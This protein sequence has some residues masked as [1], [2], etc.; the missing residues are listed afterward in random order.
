MNDLVLAP[1]PLTTQGRVLIRGAQVY[2]RECLAEFLQRNGVDLERAQWAVCIGGAQVPSAMWRHTRPAPGQLIVCRRVPG[3]EAL[4]IVATIALVAFSF[5]TAAWAAPALLANVGI[6]G[7]AAY[8]LQAGIFMLGSLLINKVLPPARARLN[9]YDS[10][11]GSTY[12]LQ[13]GRNRARPYEPLGLVMGV[14]KV[15]PDFAAQPFAWFDGDDQYQAIRLHAGI[16]CGSVA[17]LKIGPT[18]LSA[19][20]DVVESRQGFPTGNT[21][22]ADWEDVDTQA[23]AALDA[24]SGPGAWV[25]RTSSLNTVMLAVDLVA[26]L[27]AMANDGT[28]QA[29]LLD[30]DLEYRALPAGSW[31]PLTGLGSATVRLESRATKPVRRT[32]RSP[33]LAP[34]QYEVRVRKVTAN[35]ATTSKSNAVEWTALKSYQELSGSAAHPQLALRIRAT[36]QLNGVLDEVSWIATQREIP[37][38]T[39]VAWVDQV[40]RNP[41]AH[42]LRLAR[43]IY[44]AGR[45]QAG[46][47]LPDDQIDIETLQAFMVHCD[48]QGYVFDH[49]FDAPMSCIDML[50][51]IAAAGLGSISWHPGKLSV[52]WLAAGQPIEDVVSMANIKAGSFAV[53]YTTL[54]AADELE[55]TWFDRDADWAARSLRLL[56]PGVVTPRETARYAPVGVTTEAGAVRAGRLTMAQNIYQRKSVSWEMDLEHMAFRRWSVIAL[57]HD[58]TQWG[59]SGRL[60]GAVDSLGTVTLTLDEAVPWNAGAPTRKLGLRIP[61]EVGYRLFDLAVFAGETRTLTLVGAWPV[62]VP[63]PGDSAANPVHDT[64]WIYDFAAT[65][66]QRLR[67]TSIEPAADLRGARI[68]AVPESDAF[69]TYMSSGSYEVSVAPAAPPAIVLSNLTVTQRRLDVNYAQ[70]TELSIAFDVSGPMHSAQ[71]WGAPLGDVLQLLGVTVVSRFGPWP[72]GN[73]GDYR[74]EVR[75]FDALG[76]PGTVLGHTH[77]V[78]LG[79]ALS[80]GLGRNLLDA[81]NWVIGTSDS[82]TGGGATDW[83]A[84]GTSPGGS[85]TIVLGDGP[86]EVQRALWRALSGTTGTPGAEG[87]IRWTSSLR[88]DASKPY[89]FAVWVR[90]D[91][92]GDGYVYLGCEPN[93][94]DEVPAGTIDPNPYFFTV[95]RSVL[96][97]NRWYLLTGHVLPEGYAGAQLHLSGVYDGS[98]GEKVLSGN[99]FRWHAGVTTSYFRAFQ[100]YTT[101]SGRELLLAMP[102]VDLLDGNEPSTAQLIAQTVYGSALASAQALADIADDDLLTPGEKPRVILDWSVISGEQAGIDA[103]ASARNFTTEQDA[104]DDAITALSTYLGTLTTPVAWNNLSGN[105]TI[106]GATFRAKFA[107]V[108]AARQTL[109]N[110]IAGRNVVY[111]Q[112]SA[113]SGVGELDGDLWFDTDDGNRVYMRSGGSWATVDLG[114]GALAA[115]AATTGAITDSS[116]TTG[117]TGS[118]GASTRNCT[119]Y[120]PYVTTDAGDELDI[121][122]SGV[123]EETFWSQALYGKVELKMTYAA[124]FG[125]SETEFATRRKFIVPIDVY[126][127]TTHIPIDMAVQ[128]VPGAGSR[129]LIVRASVTYIDSS[130]AAVTCAKDFVGNAQ[131][132]VTRRKR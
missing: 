130:G 111:R 28:M 2:P 96:T 127:T 6:T 48:A 14:V 33:M 78:V 132:R 100:F 86:D 11:T 120:G 15:V 68:T 62:G 22:A 131:W 108:Y 10:A 79:E 122:V 13:G 82:Q 21:T 92:G 23:G 25:T 17:T 85:N 88:V 43:G 53:E 37:V 83:N 75:P 114:T 109:L 124:T 115:H 76:R 24:P 34:G 95:N 90:V 99:D 73:D 125:G 12:S 67:V 105:T 57:S 49:W 113:P 103:Q 84:L 46:L 45:L 59:Y 117:S 9:N 3:K 38:W 7:L 112:A 102:R 8:G 16:D 81:S 18:P 56:A 51:A 89:R 32:V 50:E 87:G 52:V 101:G 70:G 30:V 47:G 5:G 63:F 54:A 66:G 91:G 64:I 27:Y 58:L 110:R 123:L 69:W 104:Y 61:G 74:I 40:S 80:A 39:G 4:R 97:P 42:I 55:V 36:G 31:A 41:G 116:E 93:T 1:H 26:Q 29:A 65:P 20:S 119:L 121:V 35:V 94:V 71:V 72:V 77:S 19:Y 126:T 118:P 106:V 128:F 107:D 44:F 98:S 129:Y 60:L